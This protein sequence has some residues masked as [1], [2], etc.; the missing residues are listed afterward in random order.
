MEILASKLK[1]VRQDKQ[2]TQKSIA[3]FLGMTPNA[4][5][6]YELGTRIPDLETLVK[7]T[8]FYNISVDYLLG[9][10][11]EPAINKPKESN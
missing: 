4:Y 9:R 1:K 6:K 2:M 5:Q 7:L 3:D 8:D 10:T 11:A